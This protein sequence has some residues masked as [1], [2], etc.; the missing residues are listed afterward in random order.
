MTVDGG[1]TVSGETFGQSDDILRVE[2]ISKRYGAVLMDCQ[3]PEMDGY[4]ATRA[5]RER[6]GDARHTPIIAMTA[7]AMQADRDKALA[8]GMDDYITKPVA[9][10]RLANVLTR[11]VSDDGA[12]QDAPAP[13]RVASSS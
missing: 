13:A 8:A 11:W 10:D 6:E 7:G 4:E 3:M 1:G 2:H 5:I 12:G 9:L